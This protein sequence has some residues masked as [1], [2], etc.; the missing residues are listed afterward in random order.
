MHCTFMWMLIHICLQKYTCS[1]YM[2]MYNAVLLIWLLVFYL[3]GVWV[4]SCIVLDT[5]WT[6]PE[7]K[8]TDLFFFSSVFLL[9]PTG[10]GRLYRWHSAGGSSWLHSKHTQIGSGNRK[11]KIWLMLQQLLPTHLFSNSA[12]FKYTITPSSICVS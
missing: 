7:Q 9:A 1:R 5:I 10:H 4:N 6:S 2:P 12:T 11:S 3:S 8:H